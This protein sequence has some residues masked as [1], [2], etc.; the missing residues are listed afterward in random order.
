MLI[1]ELAEADSERPETGNPLVNS[2]CAIFYGLEERLPLVL[3]RF[4]HSAC[5]QDRALNR[6]SFGIIVSLL[7]RTALLVSQSAWST[8]Q[9]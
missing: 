3:P 1:D 7:A 9:S 6:K 5:S 4:R 2:L 8:G